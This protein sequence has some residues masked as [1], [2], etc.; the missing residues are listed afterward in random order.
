[1][2]KLTIVSIKIFRA[3]AEDKK[4]Y[5]SHLMPLKIADFLWDQ[6]NVGFGVQVFSWG[7]AAWHL[8][9]ASGYSGQKDLVAARVPPCTLALA[10]RLV[11]C[12][13]GGRGAGSCCGVAMEPA[14]CCPPPPPPWAAATSLAPAFLQGPKRRQPFGGGSQPRFGG[15]ALGLGP[16]ISCLGPHGNSARA[17]VTSPGSLGTTL[18]SSE[19]GRW[20]PPWRTWAT[21]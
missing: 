2:L 8:S 15:K 17:G 9:L 6:A 5:L 7:P 1:M 13:P 12:V 16:R 20:A 3:F 18:S 11:N 21:S 10:L 14:H 19:T 4:P